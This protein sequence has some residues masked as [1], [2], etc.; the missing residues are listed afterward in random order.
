MLIGVSVA[1]VIVLQ[2]WGSNPLFTG[3]DVWAWPVLNKLF[4]AYMAPALIA[5][6]INLEARRQNHEIVAQAAA[7]FA[8]GLIFVDLTLEIRHLFHGNILNLGG[9]SSAEGYGYSIA[10][11][12]FAGALLAMGIVKRSTGLRYASLGMMLLVVAK[13]F[14]W[15]MSALTGLY[16]VGSFLALGL[17]LIAVGYFYQR[18]VFPP[19]DEESQAEADVKPGLSN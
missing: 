6:L 3:E 8:F 18:V 12:I 2:V 17:S 9:I 10:W 11:L 19:D 13:V 14:L 4:L 1:Q 15:D 16:R 5:I 7:I